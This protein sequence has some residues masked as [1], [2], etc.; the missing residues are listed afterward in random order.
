MPVP[1]L[2]SVSL[3]NPTL[4]VRPHFEVGED[5]EGCMSNPALGEEGPVKDNHTL[6]R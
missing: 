1:P 6:T 2:I 4:R 5:G 3:S